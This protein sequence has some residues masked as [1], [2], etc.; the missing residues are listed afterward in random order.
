MFVNAKDVV[1]PDIFPQLNET[2]RYFLTCLSG[3]RVAR[4]GFAAILPGP[5]RIG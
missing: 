2:D 1:L 4:R 5:G 3:F